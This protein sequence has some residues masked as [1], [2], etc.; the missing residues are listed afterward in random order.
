MKAV[1]ESIEDFAAK[2]YSARL[3][4]HNF[5]HATTAAAAGGVICAKC[6]AAGIDIN[7]DVVYTALIFHDA[8]FHLD[9][10]PLGFESKEAYSAHLAEQYLT[11]HDYKPAFIRQVAHAILCT[12]KDARP[13]SNEDKAVRMADIYNVGQDYATFL[14]NTDK[15]YREVKLL[16]KGEVSWQQFKGIT[17][18]ILGCYLNDDLM[19]TG[20]DKQFIAQGVA[21]LQRLAS[22]PEPN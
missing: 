22:E 19:I 3:P 8:G 15:F 10:R 5:D 7:P 14:K 20:A 4:Y 2:L 17:Q 18:Q 6:Q 13:Q 21:N 16:T 12:H 11:A 9:H 1:T